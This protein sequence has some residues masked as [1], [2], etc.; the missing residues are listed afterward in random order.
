MLISPATPLEVIPG[1]PFVQNIELGKFLGAGVFGEDPQRLWTIQSFLVP[2]RRRALGGVRTKLRDQKNFITFINQRDLEVLLGLGTPGQPC[3]WLKKR[4]P[5][6]E[7]KDWIGFY[8][9]TEDLTDD[10]YEQEYFIRYDYPMIP[11]GTSVTRRIH[12]EN[13]VDVI[14]TDILLWD[15]DLEQGISPDMRHSTI[16]N[17]W[18]RVERENII[19]NALPGMD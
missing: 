6:P 3:F 10:L 17:R 7:D 16:N 4:Y 14:Q 12:I 5:G 9:D 11:E 19:W 1:T 13:G 8:T 18:R 15:A 2:S